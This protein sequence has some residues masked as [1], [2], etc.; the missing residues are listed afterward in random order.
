MPNKSIVEIRLPKSSEIGAESAS[1]LFASLA[2]G[3]QSLLDKILGK[4]ECLS[5]E[6]AV[7]NQTIHFYLVVPENKSSYIESQIVAQYPTATL[8]KTSPREAK[9]FGAAER[10]SARSHVN[11]VNARALQ[12]RDANQNIFADDYLDNFKSGAVSATQLALTNPFYFP[13]KTYKDFRD[14]DPLSSILGTLAKANPDEKMLI[15]IVFAPAS[16]KWQKIASRVIEKGITQPDGHTKSHPQARL[17]EQKATTVGFQVGIRLLVSTPSPTVTAQLLGNLVGAFG[18]FNNGEGN[19]L[20]PRDPFFIQKSAFTNSIYTRSFSFIPKRQVLNADELATIF[21]FPNLALSGIKNIAW[22]QSLIGEPPSNLPTSLNLSEEEKIKI[23]FFARTQ[24]KNS[25]AVFGIK[26]EDR[27]KHMYIIG[28]TG[29]GKSTLIANMAVS[30]MKNKHG[31]AVIDPHGDLCNILLDYVP[32]HRINDIAYLDPS[33]TDHP[34]HLNPLEVKNPA[35]KELVASGIVSIFYKLYH[36]SWGP[37]LEYILRNTILTLLE[38]PDS[39]FLM[40]PE[41]LTNNNFRQK[42]VD[43]LS[44]QVLKN[45]WLN[46]FNKMG[47]NMRIESIMPI[48]NKVGQFLSS[49]MIRNIIG[50]PHST[51]DLEDAMNN[52]K[53]IL[54]NLSQGKLGED[55]SALL[56]AMFITKLQLAAMNRVNIPESERKDFYLY[57]DEFQN[58]ATISFVKILSEA[59]KYRLNL[60]LANQYTFQ[61]PEEISKAIFG[62]VGTLISFLV[63]ADDSRL[64]SREFGQIYKEEDLVGLGNYQIVLKLAIDNLTST[65]FHATTLPLPKSLNQNREKVLR[66]SQERYTKSV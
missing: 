23:N 24:F 6:I 17:I 15:Q 52:G 12:N 30:D 14:V 25:D 65:P 61:L 16:S 39:T 26:Q 66:A 21:H 44:D 45:F 37:R 62:N 2:S 40:V 36:Y 48:L 57:V 22:G 5:A 38:V 42:V 28:K 32:S 58:F 9:I 20:A 41:I 29:T 54:L 60:A 53:I 33:D 4:T 18:V 63:G 43:K 7:F 13:L 34:F 59:R 11:K 49:P 1:Q 55:S 64:L 27:R 47:E 19:L 31:L 35:H 56:G 50:H 51:I 46:E 10:F 8:L 3:S